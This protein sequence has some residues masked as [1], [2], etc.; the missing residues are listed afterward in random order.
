MTKTQE[1]PDFPAHFPEVFVKELHDTMPPVRKIL[2]RISLKDPMKL[3]KT[4][5]LKAPQALMPKLNVWIDKPLRGGILQR[6][7]VPGGASMFLEAKSDGRIRPLWDL[8]FRYDNTIADHSQIPNQQTILHAVARGKY[9]SMRDLSD[10]YFQTIVH[11][12]DVKYN[13]I[14]TRLGNLQARS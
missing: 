14:K 5:T 3:L 1:V 10:A 4:P 11:S 6:R 9:R 7:P 8:H 13:T 2:H 12:D